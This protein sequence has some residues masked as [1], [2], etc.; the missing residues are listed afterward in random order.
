MMT[1]VEAISGE[2]PAED[3]AWFKRGLSRLNHW[4]NRLFASR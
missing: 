3:A 4:V 1:R 2:I